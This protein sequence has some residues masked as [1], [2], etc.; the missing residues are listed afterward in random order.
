MHPL[1]SK[2]LDPRDPRAGDTRTPD[3]EKARLGQRPRSYMSAQKR[4]EE[5]LKAE[6]NATPERRAELELQARKSTRQTVFFYD[7][8]FS[9][10]KSVSL[11]H[12]SL[13]AAGRDDEAQIVWDGI[14]AGNQ[15]G[16]EYLQNE[17]GYSRAGYHG[18][19]V[20]GRSTGH[21]VDAHNWVVASFAQHTS[22]DGDPQLHVHNAILNRVECDDGTWRSVDGRAVFNARPAAAAIAER[23]TEEYLSRELG[24]EFVSRPDGR[25]REIAGVAEQTRELFSARRRAVKDRVAALAADYE[26][27]HGRA[28]SAWQLQ[29]MA[30]FATLDTRAGKS[31]YQPDRAEFL[32]RW[33]AQAAQREGAALSDIPG[34]ALYRRGAGA[35]A[36]AQGPVFD[37]SAV[38]TK[39]VAEAGAAKAAWTRYD[40]IRALNTHLP[41]SLGGLSV[42][43]AQ[44]V[45]DELADAALTGR[46]PA[47]E[48][49]ALRPPEVV[50]TP[51]ALRR[52]DGESV[53]ERHGADLYATD[54]ILAREQALLEAAAPGARRSARIT[55]EEAAAHLADSPLRGAQRGAVEGI[56]TSG[57]DLEVLTAA[58][59]TGKSKTVGE[60]AGVW[61]AEHGA[62]TV[63]GLSLAQNAAQ[64]MRAEGITSAQNIDKF[65]DR[66]QRGDTRIAPESVLVVDEAGMVPTRHLAKIHHAAQQAGAKLLLTG[67]EQQLSA[68]EA[69]GAFPL[70]AREDDASV[71]RLE[72]VR[73]FSAGWEGPA[74]LRLRDK[75]TTVLAEYETRGRLVDGEADEMATQAY[76]GF[77]AD[78]LAGWQSLLLTSSNET[79]AELSS[80]AR[81]DLVRLGQVEA[82]GAALH[83]G[84]QA[85]VGD[86]IQ[87]RVNNRRLA[88]DTDRWVVN[89]DVYRVTGRNQQTGALSARLDRGRDPITGAQRWGVEVTLPSTYVAEHVELAYASTTH[90]AQ[91]RT[92]DTAH[93][94]VDENTAGGQLYV[95]LSRGRESNVAYTALPPAGID[96][97]TGQAAERP[98]RFAVLTGVLEQDSGELSATETLRNETD[99]QTH[100]G[101]LGAIWADQIETHTRE[102]TRAR[103]VDTL[104]TAGAEV[105]TADDGYR[106]LLARVRAAD[107]D[108]HDGPGLLAAAA[109][110][111]DLTGARS[112][113]AV[114]THRLERQVDM[115]DAARADEMRR[116]TR[117][118][119]EQ[120]IQTHA[121]AATA[122]LQQPTRLDG[123]ARIGDAREHETAHEAA[124]E[125]AGALMLST[126]SLQADSFAWE[127]AEAHPDPER[128]PWQPR[129]YTERTPHVP[130]PRGTYLRQLAEAMDTRMHHLGG[131]LAERVPDWARRHLGDVPDDPIDRQD[132]T[133][134]A[135]TVAAY[136][137]HY[138]HDQET[139]PLGPAPAQTHADAHTAWHQAYTALGAPEHQRDYAAATDGAL[140]RIRDAWTRAKQWAP[141]Y[142]AEQLR[143]ASTSAREWA[144]QATL[145]RAEA[146][147]ATDP[148]QAR[149]LAERA[150]R[151]DTWAAEASERRDVLEGL[152][153]ERQW[154]YQHTET[155]RTQ[156]QQAETHLHRRGLFPETERDEAQPEPEAD[157]AAETRAQPGQT[158]EVAAEPESERRSRRE[159]L[160]EAGQRRWDELTGRARDAATTTQ[161]DPAE[162]KPDPIGEPDAPAAQPE[163]QGQQ[164]P[165]SEPDQAQERPVE[166]DETQPATDTDA[167]EGTG[168]RGEPGGPD[169][170]D[171]SEP[172]PARGA[173]SSGA[174]PAQLAGH[175]YST[176]KLQDALDKARAQR[177]AAQAQQAQ[178]QHDNQQTD[179]SDRE[180]GDDYQQRQRRE[181]AQRTRR[182]GGRELGE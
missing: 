122:T 36:E 92:V 111:R 138:G 63:V 123:P 156:A 2:F 77:L 72:E 75:D 86:L 146:D 7:A 27:K 129:S 125:S 103:L 85:G 18:R 44:Q 12:A 139:D 165:R 8:T 89:R 119:R 54:T 33:E 70:L 5:A 90:A 94:L 39:A 17:A 69:G 91:G 3:G 162:R 124:A 98:D 95:M 50:A 68:P 64:V 19:K 35:G 108:G 141:P 105:V 148:E 157:T 1:Y 78:H 161:Q 76:R 87:T 153:Q 99:R 22:R 60:L 178:R 56:L 96:A 110:E 143:K 34:A 131:R 142:V 66:Y 120:H 81:A 43:Q 79:A 46:E 41:D 93:A 176:Q 24:V 115:A 160:R 145:T 28:P 150:A 40:L 179:E 73:R 118:T 71:Y 83:D 114:L 144:Q 137:E 14:M 29:R 51:D 155:T 128:Q 9:A 113:A 109:A 180:P 61:E 82:D 15:A 164:Q 49:V 170:E 4:L 38:I 112:P 147:A 102:A 181:T 177:E 152:H 175:S 11:L 104:G 134:R 53:Y 136:R 174:E 167:A 116:H 149:T 58:A 21:Y 88:G 31:G 42:T 130:G 172:E 126:A 67:D 106:H 168:R 84:T 169:R 117:I 173:Y 166:R 57:R 135:E 182:D 80:H 140:L 20:A 154:W 97:E 100:L 74:S 16:L 65:L 133:R 13:Q 30:Q 37:P 48:V 163:R 171:R 10:Q 45:L 32:A 23:A 25:G 26:T 62:G 59:G 158:A 127:A 121:A 52:A 132:W 159:R 6:P 55:P 101:H 107:A 151:R 47:A